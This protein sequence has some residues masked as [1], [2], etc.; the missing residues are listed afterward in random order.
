MNK[1][2]KQVAKDLATVTKEDLRRVLREWQQGRGSDATIRR[3]KASLHNFYDFMFIAGYVKTRPTGNLQAPK[4]WEKVPQAPASEDL[5]RTI[6]A[7]G[8]DAITWPIR[9][10]TSAG[11]GR[12]R[13]RSAR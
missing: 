10:L 12:F 6:S 13:I 2:Q 4:G 5:E 9:L 3:C 1:F 11:V 7:I 8:R